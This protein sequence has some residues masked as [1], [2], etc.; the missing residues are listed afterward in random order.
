MKG[1][2]KAA[3]SNMNGILKT[4]KTQ[5]EQCRENCAQQQLFKT[6]LFDCFRKPFHDGTSSLKKNKQE[7][8]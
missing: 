5:Y 2:T 8:P 4:A 3:N 1:F 6:S 7:L